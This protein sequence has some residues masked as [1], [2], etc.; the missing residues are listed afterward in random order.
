MVTVTVEL[1]TRGEYTT[2]HVLDSL[3]YQ[4]LT[5]FEVIAVNS[6]ESSKTTELL[7]NYG[8]QEIKVPQNTGHLLSRYLAN[9]NASGAYRLILDSTRPL[10][11]RALE[12][13]SKKYGNVKATCIREGSIGN[14]FWVEQSKK[15]RIL[16][17][18]TYSRAIQEKAA[19][20]LP[21][22]YDGRVLNSAFHY[23]RT[24]IEEGLFNSI[25]YGEHHLIFEACKLK[26][27]EVS[28]TDEV[29]LNHYE[30]ETLSEIYNKYRRYGEAQKILQKIG[31]RSN[32]KN[33]L[34][35]MRMFSL[36]SVPLYFQTIPIRALRTLSFLFGMLS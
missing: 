21:R 18:M 26:S 15:L 2:K 13:L 5:D 17:E 3:R 11:P 1:I 23:L 12:L 22:F 34:S 32:A 30:D 8:V 24:N 16:S 33:L 36:N 6:S 35:H 7:R 9:I 31:Y 27:S 25:S 19:F 29:L 20:F 14:G 28:F 4:T 10:I